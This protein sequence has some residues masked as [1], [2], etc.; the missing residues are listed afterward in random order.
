MLLKYAV[1]KCNYYFFVYDIP[2]KPNCW[3]KIRIRFVG[4]ILSDG[5]YTDPSGYFLK[6]I[7]KKVGAT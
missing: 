6:L 7:A 1:K 4:N 3:E 5:S 2:E